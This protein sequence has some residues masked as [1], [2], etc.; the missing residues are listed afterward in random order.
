MI[1]L[2]FALLFGAANV[3]NAA[4]IYSDYQTSSTSSFVLPVTFLDFNDPYSGPYSPTYINWTSWTFEAVYDDIIGG[5]ALYT[6]T[7]VYNNTYHV[8][9]TVSPD[10]VV[11]NVGQ[12]MHIFVDTMIDPNDPF[13]GW[14]SAIYL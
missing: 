8:H 6:I 4:L 11:L 13:M 3:A 1:A 12:Y 5:Y 9:F 2:S 7:D 10:K 14:I